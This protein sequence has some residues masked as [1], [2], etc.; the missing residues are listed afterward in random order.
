MSHPPLLFSCL[1][2][3]VTSLHLFACLSSLMPVSSVLACVFLYV[4]FSLLSLASLSCLAC[5]HLVFFFDSLLSLVCLLWFVA[6]C[7]CVCVNFL[8]I[9]TI[10]FE[11][12]CCHV[13]YLPCAPLLRSHECAHG[14]FAMCRLVTSPQK[15]ARQIQYIAIDHHCCICRSMYL[16][17]CCSFPNQYFLFFSQKKSV[18]CTLVCLLS[19]VCLLWLVALCVCVCV[20]LCQSIVFFECL[21]C[22]VFYLPCAPLL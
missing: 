15:G 11:C 22:H 7:V 19:L 20:N 13:F 14:A 16:C 1:P 3:R 10:L 17:L 21:C 5:L 18:V 12:L 9:N 6:L 4:L 2:P 8:P